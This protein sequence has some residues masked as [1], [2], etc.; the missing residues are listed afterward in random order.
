MV[1]P[2]KTAQGIFK[3]CVAVRGNVNAP[4]EIV[5]D[6]F[7]ILFNARTTPCSVWLIS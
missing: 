5:F 2:V 7:T 4:V 1:A 3:F 6:V